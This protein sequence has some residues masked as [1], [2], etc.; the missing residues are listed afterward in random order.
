[1]NPSLNHIDMPKARTMKSMKA[2]R[3]P[4]GR[5]IPKRRSTRCRG[6]AIGKSELLDWTDHEGIRRPPSQRGAGPNHAI[7]VANGT[8]ALELCLAGLGIGRIMAVM[9]KM[10]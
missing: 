8:V 1:M 6:A 2:F 5:T 10:R 9:Q 7:A 4:H 3:Q